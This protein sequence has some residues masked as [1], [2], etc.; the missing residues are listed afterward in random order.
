MK[1]IIKPA[2]FVI[3]LLFLF[4]LFGNIDFFEL[5]FAWSRQYEILEL[6]ELFFILI[7]M[8]VSAT[9]FAA[10]KLNEIKEINAEL[11]KQKAECNKA[12]RILSE[13]ENL[14][15]SIFE[16]MHEGIIALDNNFQYIIWNQAMEKISGGYSQEYVV[17]SKKRPWELFPFLSQYGIDEMMREAMKGKASH[18]DNLVWKNCIT[19]E[20]FL[21]LFSDTGDIKGVI[22]VVRDTSEQHRIMENLKKSEERYREYFEENLAGTFILSSKRRLIACNKMFTDIFGFE[23]LKEAQRIPFSDFFIDP[24]IRTKMFNRL[25]KEKRI[26]GFEIDL[27]KSDGSTLHLVTN[28]SAEFDK[29]GEMKLVRGFLMD[30][31]DQKHLEERFVQVQKMEA[32]GTLAGGIAHDFNNILFPI[33][34]YSQMLLS[35]TPQAHPSYEHL[36]QI[37]TGALRA[38]DLVRQILTFSRQGDHEINLIKLQPIIKEVL[39]LIRSTIPTSI[40]ISEDI[41][42]DCGIIKADPTQI[43]QVIMNLCTNAYHAMIDTGGQLSISLKETLLDEQNPSIADLKPGTYACLIVSDTGVG[44]GK[45]IVANIFD[46]FFTTKIN[47]KGTGLGLSVVHGII[48]SLNG[49]IQVNTTPGIGTEFKIYFPCEK[50]T[51]HEKANLAKTSLPMGNEHILLIDDERDIVNM[52][53]ELLRKLGYRVTSR[54]SSIEALEAFRAVPNRFD[55]IITDMAMPKLPGDKLSAE[56]IRINPD[57]PILLCTGFSESITEEKTQAIGIKGFLTKPI[58]LKDLAEKIRDI[59][60]A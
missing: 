42:K 33:L 37:H 5:F 39:K 32:I 10:L 21:P 12:K 60:D 9:L 19:S 2:L 51:F 41:Q 13:R 55:M 18:K 57:I 54:T 48:K 34:G 8:L 31:T 15:N 59:L 35:E 26:R 40:D 30:V 58:I 45:D 47:G 24:T 7:I 28:V 17:G 50:T 38:K 1:K 53:S 14:H 6:D 27:K 20:S 22:G 36:E 3:L 11:Q 46:P 23:D 25:K 29:N 49:D 52:I 16:S 43:H 44:M 4:F 56:I